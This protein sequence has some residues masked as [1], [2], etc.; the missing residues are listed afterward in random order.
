MQIETQ[1]KHLDHFLLH[2]EEG[3]RSNLE[4]FSIVPIRSCVKYKI[5]V[6]SSPKHVSKT[7]N[8]SPAASPPF[9]LL[10]FFGLF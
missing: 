4:I 7:P 2:A 8:D 3:L 10:I 1:R 5:N 6:D 9:L